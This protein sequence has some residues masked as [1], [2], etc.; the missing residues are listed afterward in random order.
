[1]RK[2]SLILL[3]F[4]GLLIIGCSN[5]KNSTTN[6]SVMPQIVQGALREVTLE[7]ATEE[8]DIIAN[9]TITDIADVVEVSFD[10]WTTHEYTIY[11]AKINRYFYDDLSYGEQIKFLQPGGPN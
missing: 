2:N 7:Q 9:I 3:I 4:I 5:E 11:E 6:E 10:E 1:M 8:A